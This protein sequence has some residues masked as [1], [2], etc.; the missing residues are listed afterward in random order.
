MLEAFAPVAP[1]ALA[2]PH[3]D[4]QILVPDRTQPV[5]HVA[6][7][8][9]PGGCVPL[10]RRVAQELPQRASDVAAPEPEVVEGLRVPPDR[11]VSE[12]FPPL[13]AECLCDPGGGVGEAVPAPAERTF[14]PRARQPLDDPEGQPAAEGQGAL[15][16]VERPA[17]WHPHLPT[18]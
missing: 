12:P 9:V 15:G 5:L 16:N 1:D 3:D 10:V 4:C 14:C 13:L 11:V 2:A 6:F 8:E 17:S 7:G 18:V